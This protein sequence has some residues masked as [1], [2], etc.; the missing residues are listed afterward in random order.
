MVADLHSRGTHSLKEKRRIISSIKDKLKQKF[1]ISIIESGH[2]D[3]WQ[4]IQLAVAMVSN[5]RPMIE[6]TFDQVEDF[7]CSNY[8]VQPISVDKEY[9]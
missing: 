1:N 7:I 5:A 2:Q 8:P 9:I 3:S 6:K 4:Q